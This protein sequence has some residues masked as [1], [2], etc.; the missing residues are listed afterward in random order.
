MAAAERLLTTTPLPLAEIAVR[1]GFSTVEHFS[2]TF[3]RRMGKT[4]ASAR[5]APSG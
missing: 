4:P 5:Q 3:R 1:V 2:A